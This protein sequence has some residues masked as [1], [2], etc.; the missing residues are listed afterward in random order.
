MKNDSGTPPGGM[1]RQVLKSAVGG[2]LGASVGVLAWLM[3]KADSPRFIP[4][5][6]GGLGVLAGVGLTLPGV[7]AKR[8]AKGVAA[9]MLPKPLPRHLKQEVFDWAFREEKDH[10]A[11]PQ[12]PPPTSSDDSAR[13]KSF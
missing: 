7:S 1:V 3:L 9:G 13:N 2:L 11:Q 5:I 8:V 4:F 10:A 6:F 12:G